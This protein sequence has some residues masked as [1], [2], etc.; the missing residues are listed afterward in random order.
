[1]RALAKPRML[2]ALPRAIYPVAARRR[3]PR[4]GGEARKPGSAARRSR[5]GGSMKLYGVPQSPFVQKARIALEEKRLAYTIEPH[6]PALHPLGKMPVL[7]DGA[8]VIPDS[9]VIC[10]YLERTHPTPALY[11]DDPA[12]LARALFLEEYADARMAEGMGAIVL[13]RIVKPQMLGQPTDEARL[14]ELLA[15]ARERWFGQP[16]A[17]SGSPIPSVMDYLE[18]QLPADRDTVL[19]RFGIADIA[20]GAHLAWIDAAGLPLDASRWPRVARYRAALLARPSF[21]TAFA[22]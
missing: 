7:R 3:Q 16:L 15:G 14:A 22:F 1:M 21:K 4:A 2:D 19:A 17:A 8:L 5:S 18:S 6:T 9:S 11:P 13:E 20:L 10:A 12:E